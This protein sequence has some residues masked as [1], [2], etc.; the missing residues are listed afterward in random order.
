MYN[1][2]TLPSPPEGARGCLG[3]LGALSRVREREGPD[4]KRW[5]GEGGLTKP[6]FR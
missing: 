3:S 1:P 5:E 6:A 2:L 4:A